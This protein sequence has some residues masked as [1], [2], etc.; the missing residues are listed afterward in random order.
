M[1]VLSPFTWLSHCGGNEI[2]AYTLVLFIKAGNV[3]LCF[4]KWQTLKRVTLI[5]ITNT[6]VCVFRQ[7]I[8]EKLCKK[9]LVVVGHVATSLRKN[10]RITILTFKM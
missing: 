9:N 8:R 4:K 7:V 2:I 1:Y 6:R 5:D 10:S 3:V